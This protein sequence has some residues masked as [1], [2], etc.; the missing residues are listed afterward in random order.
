MPDSSDSALCWARGRAEMCHV[1]PTILASLAA[2][3]LALNQSCDP[4]SS[5]SLPSLGGDLGAS[6]E[7]G[8]DALGTISALPMI[9]R[10][11]YSKAKS[12]DSSLKC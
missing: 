11:W 5:L 3:W 6:L 2:I 7:T 4:S 10:K 12:P 9:F 8:I 1:F